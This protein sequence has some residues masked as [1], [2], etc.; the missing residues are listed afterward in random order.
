MLTYHLRSSFTVTQKYK[1]LPEFKNHEQIVELNDPA[2]GLKGFIAIHSTVLGPATG[3]T[4]YWRYNSAQL[5]IKDAL[6]LSEAMSYKCALAGVPFGGGKAVIMAPKNQLK[7][8]ALL[9][10]FAQSI[11]ALNGVFSTGEDIGIEEKDI[12]LMKRHSPYINGGQKSG[13]LGPWAA[14]G[15]FNALKAALKTTNKT[16]SLKNRKIAIKGL[17][18][19]GGGLCKLI[20]EQGGQVIGSDINPK[21]IKNIKK[22]FPGITLVPPKIIHKQTVDVF[23]PCALNGDLNPKTILELKCKIVC[24]G[25]NNQ[26]A[27]ENCGE[28]LR[29]KGILY[30]PDF[31]ANAGGLINAVAERHNGHYDKQWVIKKVNHISATANKIIAASRQSGL[32][33]NVI[34]KKMA[35]RII[36]KKPKI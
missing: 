21:V 11:N 29:K 16:S 14:L 32:P 27:F 12:T 17:G 36:T 30:I 13:S 10:K 18:K 28:L 24:G 6:R 8:P 3:G 7:T 31:V 1:L 23:S 15:V 5:A 25:A 22:R 34:A 26:L 35:E 4:R 2:S 9:K 19:V 20:I 33:T